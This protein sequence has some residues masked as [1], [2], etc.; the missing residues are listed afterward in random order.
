MNM[1]RNPLS[2]KQKVRSKGFTS[3]RTSESILDYVTPSQASHWQMSPCTSR[4]VAILG[5]IG[6]IPRMNDQG[7][8]QANI[9]RASP[10]S[11]IPHSLLTCP[12]H[13]PSIPMSQVCHDSQQLGSCTPFP[14]T[15]DTPDPLEPVRNVSRQ[16][17]L[18]VAAV[19][20]QPSYPQD[21]GILTPHSYV[22]ESFIHSTTSKY[23]R[24]YVAETVL[25]TGYASGHPH[26]NNLTFICLQGEAKQQGSL[27]LKYTQ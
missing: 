1:K 22:S 4:P 10:S 26:K 9:S 14:A 16:Q 3:A 20:A 2:S 5:S 12:R 18:V 7:Q 23:S 17:Q 13:P 27:R 6:I 8:V 25:N 19:K 11:S 21:P 15:G 24:N